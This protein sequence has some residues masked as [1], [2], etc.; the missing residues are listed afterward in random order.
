M[1]GVQGPPG[2]AVD[3]QAAAWRQWLISQ[4]RLFEYRVEQVRQ[5]LVGDKINTGELERLLNGFA[6]QGWAV[7]SITPAEVKGRVGPGGTSGL[8]VVFERPVTR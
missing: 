8:L 3:P 5:T 6:Q 2:G 7:K 4:G 1:T